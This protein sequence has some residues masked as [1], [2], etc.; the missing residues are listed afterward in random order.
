MANN[1]TVWAQTRRVS[2]ILA[3]LSPVVLLLAGCGGQTSMLS[4]KRPASPPSSAQ[5]AL[6]PATVSFGNVPV[7]TSAQQ[8]VTLTNSGQASAQITSVSPSGS[9]FGVTAASLPW[10]IAPNQ[11]K[12]FSVSF[13]PSAPGSAS[14]SVA[15]AGDSSAPPLPLSGTGMGAQINVSPASLDF[16]TVQVGQSATKTLTI[17]N[18][19]NAAAVISQLNVSGD[20]AFTYS[21]VT[22]PATIQPN[23]SVQVNVTYAPT[24]ATDP[25]ATLVLVAN[26]PQSISVNLVGSASGGSDLVASPGSLDFG[27]LAAGQTATQTLT[28]TDTGTV[29]ATITQIQVNGATDFSYSGANLPLSIAPN[30]SATLSVT[31]SAP[32]SGSSSAT[33]V[34]TDGQPLP[35]SVPLSGGNSGTVWYIRDDGGTR[36]QCTGKTNA[37]Y[38]G[39]G[40]GQPCAF[41]NPFWLVTA[42]QT[43]SDWS[44]IIAGGDTVLFEPDASGSA[45]VYYM[46][47]TAGAGRAGANLPKWLHCGADAADC[48]LPAPPNGTAAHPTRILGANFGH[49]HNSAHTGLVGP[50]QLVAINGE[51][52]TLTLQNTDF[53]DLEC[54][55]LTDAAGCTSV[56]QA[57][58]CQTGQDYGSHGLFFEYLVNQGP[59]NLTMRDVA[60]HGMASDGISGG[61]FNTAASDVT[62]LSDIYAWGNGASGWDYDGGGCGIQCESTGTINISYM[63]IEWNGCAEAYPTGSAA[64][65][66]AANG[67]NYCYDDNDGG[68]G[69]GLAIIATSGAWTLDHTTFKYN[70]QDGLDMLHIADQSGVHP[71]QV[72]L[73]N[74]W[75][76]GNMGQQFKLGFGGVVTIRNNVAIDNCRRLSEPFAPNPAGYNTGLSD[77]CRAAGDQWDLYVGDGGSLTMQFNT[78]VGYGAT[79]YDF[80]CAVTCT[81]NYKFVFEDNI[82]LGIPDP[83]RSGTLPG[84]FYEASS[85]LGTMFTNPGSAL[86]HNLWFQMKNGCPAV[87]TE[88]NSVCSDPLLNNE[89]AGIDAM[90][91]FGSWGL[92]PADPGQPPA[93]PSGATSPTKVSPAVGAGIAIPGVDSDL[94]G[95]PI[96]TLVT[97]GALQP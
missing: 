26:T 28:L 30:A 54:L 15:V 20:A 47:L 5:L 9:N 13:D 12:T 35:L 34:V 65:Q 50:P 33:L 25:S 51:F 61:K 4:S 19:G 59:S 1:Y 86:D 22:L 6:S 78:T 97:I 27:S 14:G 90:S 70:T 40:S 79:M 23:A 21:G 38:P 67:Y 91:A 42:N 62:T 17:G 80:G 7:G 94:L 66:P 2:M 46:G 68:Y 39:S 57:G 31:Y 85:Q 88:T 58:H 49:C 96:S 95:N 56:A 53:I 3:I 8:T 71:S 84:G 45:G 44:W 52:Y 10:T 32:A 37:A 64:G 82:S 41:N 11:A 87:P 77:F 83:G 43:A 63:D 24:S 29:A 93:T 60:V 75:A 89:S 81:T 16:G 92:F 55:D 36:Q 18:S 74:S 69:D 76:E 72:T 48:V 73:E